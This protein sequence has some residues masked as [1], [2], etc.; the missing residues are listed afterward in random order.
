MNTELEDLEARRDKA[1]REYNYCIFEIN[2]LKWASPRD[3]EGVTLVYE[4]VEKEESMKELIR[5][6]IQ[7]YT[8]RI[9]LVK[10]LNEAGYGTKIEEVKE[11]SYSISSDFYVIIYEKEGA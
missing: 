9:E 10:A 6:K 7:S 11:F 3:R 8:A 5:L 2:N 1:I 4:P